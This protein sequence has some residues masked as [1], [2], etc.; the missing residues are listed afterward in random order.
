M[1]E[2]VAEVVN[3]QSAEAVVEAPKTESIPAPVVEPAV[4]KPKSTQLLDLA[5]REAAF[6]KQEV[7]YKTKLAE[8]QKELEDLKYFRNAKE[9]IGKNPEELLSK[10]GISYD[11]LTRNIIN[12]YNTEEEKAKT[13]SVDEIR[14]QIAAE[15]EQREVSKAQEIASA[16][17]EGFNR[18]IGE[19]VKTNEDKFPHL[20]KLG[21][22]FAGSQS[23]EE[24][25][26]DIVSNYFEETGELL[27]LQTAADTAEE[28][29]REEWNKLNGVLSGKSSA[30][31]EVA[32]TASAPTTEAAPSAQKGRSGNDVN[33]LSNIIDPYG[34]KGKRFRETI[35]PTIHNNMPVASPAP[36]KARRLERED[37]IAR[38][39]QNYGVVASKK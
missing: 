19:F 9:I 11:E 17:V 34:N 7:E 15:F 18:E 24:L 3:T 5:K 10:L 38:A 26:F 39:V 12:Y 8:A 27:D 6:R 23:T 21:S 14:K 2:N 13:P 20:T 1:S 35:V 25:V 31:V 29:F 32:A 22:T 30:P 4:E 33:E 36:F 16:A 28:Y 37:L